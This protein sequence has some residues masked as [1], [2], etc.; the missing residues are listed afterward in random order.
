MIMRLA[1]AALAGLSMPAGPASAG[2]DRAV[3]AGA[4]QFSLAEYD[5]NN[6]RIITEHGWLPG[7]EARLGFTE[8][9]WG[10][11]GKASFYQHDID[12]RGQTQSNAALAS[13][14]ATAIALI[15][16]GMSYAPDEAITLFAALEWE[17]WRR[18]INGVGNIRGLQERT[19]THRLLL[20]L[21]TRHAWS[22]YGTIGA[23]A[24]I[25]LA[26]PERLRVGFSGVL[27]EASLRTR[28]ATGLRLGL[29]LRPQAW[30][31][32]EWHL[33]VD[34]IRVGR[35][36]DAPVSRNG[37]YAGT[38]AQPEHIKRAISLGMRYRF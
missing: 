8:G 37:A 7:L 31:A 30:P 5:R 9:Q 16:G 29:S 22:P 34:R 24:A 36:A 38:V 28:S 26:Q 25:V 2:W 17:R 3:G 1:I 20:G 35:S 18:D 33:D 13:T 14:T 10:L 4:R 11:F 27:D 15:Q 21:E 6:R 32:L 12:Y 23:S 19:T